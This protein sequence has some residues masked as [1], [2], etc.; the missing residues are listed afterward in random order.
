MMT[1]PWERLCSQCFCG[2]SSFLCTKYH[3][4]RE[5]LLALEQPCEVARYGVII[6]N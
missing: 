5:C 1:L 6:C 4:T 2:Y 3:H